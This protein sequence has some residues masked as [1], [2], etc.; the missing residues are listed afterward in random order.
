MDLHLKGKTAVVTG[1]GKG[2]GLAI[3]RALAEEGA[4]VIAGSRTRTADI[5]SLEAAGAITFVEVDLSSTEGAET[6]V[7]VAAEQGGID[8]LINNVGAVTP[9]TGG[10]VSVADADWES[11]LNLTF[12]SAVRTIRAALPEMERRG[13]G[14]IV[15]VSSVNAFLPDPAVIDYSAAKAALTNLC[16]SL[17]KELAPKGI[18]VNTVSPGPVRTA[19]WLAEGGVASTLAEVSG[20]SAQE[21]VDSAAAG[22]ETGR[23]TLPEEVADLVL[24]LA[25]DRA[26]NVT[27]ADFVIDGGLIKTL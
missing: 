9:R 20:V 19:L 21:V 23:F 12:M 16:K 6:L 1:A 15:T 8:V 7:A 4:Y 5:D 27:G 13:G 14:S 18:R 24:F 26:A 10:F 22:S 25:G 11:S 2:I 17:S 3:T